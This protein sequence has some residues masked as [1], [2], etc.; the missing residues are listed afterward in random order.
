MGRTGKMKER[1][2]SCFR[3][4]VKIA[5]RIVRKD[6]AESTPT[7]GTFQLYNG[8]RAYAQQRHQYTR[9]PQQQQQQQ[10]DFDCRRRR[11]R[12]CQ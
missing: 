1:R 2:L 6:S 7:S 9:R 10:L 4:H 12:C 3:A 11:R 8:G 5:S